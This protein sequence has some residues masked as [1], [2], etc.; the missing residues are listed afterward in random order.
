MPI[1]DRS[2]PPHTPT[3]H[4]LLAPSRQ[5]PSSPHPSC[6]TMRRSPSEFWN[7]EAPID[8]LA[9]YLYDNGWM[10]WCRWVGEGAS[11]P[12]PHTPTHTPHTCVCMHISHRTHTYTHIPPPTPHHVTTHPPPHLSTHPA[13]V[14]TDVHVNGQPLLH[15]G[16]PCARHAPQAVHPVHALT[17]LLLGQDR[18]GAPPE[19]VVYLFFFWG[20]DGGITYK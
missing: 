13:A 19:L 9:A 14:R 3:P 11:I 20:G 17:A 18:Q 7:A 16:V 15:P 12:F 5:V 6:G 8:A 2:L 4:S 10:R 1:L